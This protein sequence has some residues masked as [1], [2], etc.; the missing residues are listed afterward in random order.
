M[1]RCVFGVIGLVLALACFFGVG[2]AVNTRAV[3]ASE[4]PPQRTLG[5]MGV[6]ISY[7]DSY[8]EVR[9]SLQGAGARL[10]TTGYLVF[11]VSE[12][13]EDRLGELDVEVW[14]VGA[15]DDGAD[16]EVACT[17]FADPERDYAFEWYY[18]S[19]GKY[20]ITITV[21]YDAGHYHDD[22]CIRMLHLAE[23]CEDDCENEY[24]GYC[25]DI[26]CGLEEGD[27]VDTYVYDYY[28]IC[29]TSNSP[30]F[31]ASFVLGSNTYT[32]LRLLDA[33]KKY[34]VR[35]RQRDA[36]Y[37]WPE[38]TAVYETNPDC[39]FTTLGTDGKYLI[40]NVPKKTSRYK[41]N[42]AVTYDFIEVDD[43]GKVLPPARVRETVEFDILFA[44]P[45]NKVSIWEVL[46]WIGILGGLAGIMWAVTVMAKKVEGSEGV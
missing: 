41:L 36:S 7:Y 33:G 14:L 8:N 32:E 30:N 2:A 15:G 24:D 3:S 37:Y 6:G 42:F 21:E 19:F 16:L 18:A 31:G 20:R 34:E 46:L 25:W 35:V 10:A 45:P 43:D 11:T 4:T 23:E 12:E 27:D 29:R 40:L 28:V 38:D 17:E 39:S 9:R 44:P 26:R 1:K 22:D 13:R 5:S